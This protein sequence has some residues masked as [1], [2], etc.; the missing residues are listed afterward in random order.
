[1]ARLLEREAEIEAVLDAW[2]RAR[3]GHGSAWFLCAEAGGG[4]TRLATDAARACGGRTL[5]GAAEPVT[6]PDPYLAVIRALPGFQPAATRAESVT[7]AVALLEDAAGASPII[8]VLDDLHFADEGT[9][10]VATRLA[11]LSAARP[12]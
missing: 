6:P 4:K 9:L 11:S 1:M 8:L 5:W 3:A 12:W 10:A 7:R 2:R